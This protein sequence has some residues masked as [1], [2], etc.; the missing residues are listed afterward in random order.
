M[1][2]VGLVVSFRQASGGA[3]A[4]YLGLWAIGGSGYASV[5]AKGL[6]F[7]AIATIIVCGIG[8]ARRSALAISQ[9]ERSF[10]VGGALVG[11]AVGLTT[12]HSAIIV[13]SAIG[14]IVGG[15]AFRQTPQGRQAELETWRAIVETG[16]PA[17]VAMSMIGVSLEGILSRAAAL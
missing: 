3:M 10:I 14:A 7:W 6:M 4:S 17:V 15:I 12:G 16:L 13:Y 5:S 11:M 2:S 1:L 9:R 8:F